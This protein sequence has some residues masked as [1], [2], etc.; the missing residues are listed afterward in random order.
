MKQI[1][2]YIDGRFVSGNKEFSDINP[3]DGSV[4]AQVS[5]ADAAQVDE[6]R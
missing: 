6:K 4:I 5:E 2:N 1:Q 3:A